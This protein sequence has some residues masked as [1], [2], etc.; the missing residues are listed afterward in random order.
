MSRRSPPADDHAESCSGCAGS[1][2]DA[3][4]RWRRLSWWAGGSPRRWRRRCG[5]IGRRSSPYPSGSRPAVAP[6]AE[7]LAPVGSPVRR[8]RP[9]SRRCPLCG[10]ASVGALGG[11]R[12]VPGLFALGDPSA[13]RPGSPFDV[14]ARE[15]NLATLVLLPRAPTGIDPLAVDYFHLGDTRPLAIVNTDNR[16]LAGALRRAL[17]PFLAP[18]V[19]QEQRGFLPH[20]STLA[21]VVDVEEACRVHA[22][23]A[24]RGVAVFFD[25]KAA[26]PSLGHAFLFETLAALGVP[27]WPLA[28][29]RALAAALCGGRRRRLA[30]DRAEGAAGRRADVCGRHRGGRPG[31]GGPAPVGRHVPRVALVSGLT[32]N[33]RKAALVPL[34]MEEPGSLPAFLAARRLRHGV[35]LVW[36]CLRRRVPPR[37]LAYGPCSM[38][39]A[40]PAAFSRLSMAAASGVRTGPTRWSTTRAARSSGT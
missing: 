11:G 23:T 2:R 4:T 5:C 40:P 36:A 25:F 27:A 35:L 32:L 15:F 14:V 33:L 18:W 9:G 29:I 34:S 24:A 22:A 17:E 6:D 30:A 13:C 12:V 20:R 10:V 21:N 39:G 37:R 28:A 3:R 7:R 1:A 26:F 38:V 31:L 8:L 19:S 16:L